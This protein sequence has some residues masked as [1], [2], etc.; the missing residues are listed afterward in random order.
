[1]C[2]YRYD[3]HILGKLGLE[4]GGIARDLH[5]YFQH[6]CRPSPPAPSRDRAGDCMGRIVWGLGGEGQGRNVSSADVA[7]HWL[8]PVPAHSS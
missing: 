4:I 3:R 2:S 8:F 7:L 1:M 5:G 6:R